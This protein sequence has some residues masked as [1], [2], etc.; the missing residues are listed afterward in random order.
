MIY[1]SLYLPG[2]SYPSSAYPSHR[3]N[4]CRRIV[5]TRVLRHHVRPS[6][7]RGTTIL[8]SG[9]LDAFVES[10]SFRYYS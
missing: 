4:G 10:S 2:S 5:P 9:G 3:R 7:W 6:D 1:N 8:C